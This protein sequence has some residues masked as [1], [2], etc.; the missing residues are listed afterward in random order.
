MDCEFSYIEMF[1]WAFH[2]LNNIFTNQMWHFCQSK[3]IIKIVA[4]K[5]FLLSSVL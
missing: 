2:N 3:A 5:K 1:E 4:E